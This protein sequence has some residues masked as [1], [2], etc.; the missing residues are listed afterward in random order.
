MDET[1]PA[2]VE[3]RGSS[4]PGLL[5][6]SLGDRRGCDLEQVLLLLGDRGDLVGASRA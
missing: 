1:V 2:G 3:S 5:R 6:L 4:R